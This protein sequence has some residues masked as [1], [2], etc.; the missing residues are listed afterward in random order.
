MVY[1]VAVA[2]DIT[3]W[4]AL[5]KCIVGTASVDSCIH[6]RVIDHPMPPAET[7]VLKSHLITEAGSEVA[8]GWAAVAPWRHPRPWA[9]LNN[10]QHL[11]P[12]YVV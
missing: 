7:G 12:H 10:F 5:I 4:F 8:V 11:K 1:N 2:G 6:Y 9:G 3:A